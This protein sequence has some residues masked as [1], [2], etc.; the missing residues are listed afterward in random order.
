MKLLRNKP[1][2]IESMVSVLTSAIEAR[3][4]YTFG[5]SLRVEKMSARIGKL[6]GLRPNYIEIIQLAVRLHDLGKI[7][8]PDS[9]LLREGPLPDQ[10]FQVIQ[11]HPVIAEDI[12]KGTK[13]L[14]F[15]LPFIKHH[16]ERFDGYGYPDGLAG[17]D[18]PLGA[19]LITVADA[20]DAMLSDRPYRKALTVAA[21][22]SELKVHSGNHFD[23]Q[24][25]ASI[26]SLYPIIKGLDFF[27]MNSYTVYIRRHDTVRHSIDTTRFKTRKEDK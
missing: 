19:R 22:L 12:I 27:S 1:A 4:S 8:I 9:I 20:I 7:G 3:D 5:H 26:E 25:I 10:D 18:I 6:L 11:R 21:A 16:H 23:P 17:S 2:E 13:A 14:R 15:L 24:I